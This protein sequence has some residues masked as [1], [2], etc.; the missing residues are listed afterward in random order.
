[1]VD[2]FAKG[3]EFIPKVVDFFYR[4]FNTRQRVLGLSCKGVD[5]PPQ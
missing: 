4:S 3:V 1:M 2:F 5:F